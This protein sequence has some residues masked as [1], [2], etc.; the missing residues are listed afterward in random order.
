MSRHLTPSAISRPEHERRRAGSASRAACRSSRPRSPRRGTARRCRTTRRAAATSA[1]GTRRS[2]GPRGSRS[3]SDGKI[4]GRLAG[5]DDQ[6]EDRDEQRRQQRLGRAQRLAQRALAEDPGGAHADTSCTSPATRVRRA[7]GRVEEHVVERRL[8]VEAGALAQVGLELRGRALAHD[9]PVVDDR[10]PVAELVGLLEVLRGEE[11]RRAARVDA[12]Q[13]VPDRQPA[14][15]V[16]AGGRLV[17]EQD[18]GLVHERRGEVEPALHAARVALDRRGRRRPRARRARAA[19]PC[20]SPPRSRT[21]PN[22]RAWSTSS[23]RPVWRGSS[24]ASCSATPILRR[25]PSG[26]CA[27]STPA[28]RAVPDVI[29]SS[30]VSIRTVVD[31][32]APFGPRK[33]KTSPVVDGQVDAADGLDVLAPALVRLDQ[34]LRFDCRLSRCHALH[35]SFNRLPR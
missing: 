33:P 3:T 9:P 31:L 26:S 21:R 18:V 12:A 8:A 30:V 32:P 17:E 5:V 13:L 22:S 14:R 34:I 1:A 2:P 23:S 19:R 6:E 24:P 7:A 20:G 25:A 16:Q 10:Q 15:R 27:T 28:T 29:V 4:V 11:D 35:A